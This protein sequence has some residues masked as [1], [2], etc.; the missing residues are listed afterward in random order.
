MSDSVKRIEE[1]EP[2]LAESEKSLSAFENELDSFEKKLDGIK[3]LSAYYGSEEWFEDF[4]ACENGGLPEGIK[5]GV[6]SEDEIFDL[7][8]RTREAAVKMLEMSTDI[9]KNI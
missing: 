7:I 5:C 3:A 6:L 9:I 8:L 4:E 1:Y 2:V